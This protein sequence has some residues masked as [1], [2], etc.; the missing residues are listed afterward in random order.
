ML[1]LIGSLTCNG[2][3]NTTHLQLNASNLI[4]TTL[5]NEFT[6]GNH[7]EL[8]TEPVFVLNMDRNSSTPKSVVN[9]IDD[10]HQNIA[11]ISTIQTSS[12][13]NVSPSIHKQ[14]TCDGLNLLPGQPIHSEYAQVL[15]CTVN[16]SID[17]SFV[18]AVFY[19]NCIEDLDNATAL[20]HEIF[21]P[22]SSGTQTNFVYGDSSE[23]RLFVLQNGSLFRSNLN[24]TEYDVFEAYCLFT[25][26]NGQTMALVCQ[27][28]LVSVSKAQA[29]LYAICK[30]LFK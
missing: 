25:D 23:D 16:D 28:G 18:W 6:T 27:D 12:S 3:E 8:V 10:H 2:E 13:T 20:Q 22:C 4:K 21:N 17:V 30:L 15:K 24:Y 19:E 5:S 9:A 14:E 1:L 7:V 29:Y 11:N 26:E